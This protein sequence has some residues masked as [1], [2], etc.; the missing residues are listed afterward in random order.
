MLSAQIV[1]WRTHLK[2]PDEAKLTP[3]ARDMIERLLCD[4]EH[5]LGTRSV[6]E[7]KVGASLCHAFLNEG[8]PV[9][10]QPLRS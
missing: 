3:E 8:L 6:Q 4:V 5:R 10:F 9:A 2:F 1:N 7:I